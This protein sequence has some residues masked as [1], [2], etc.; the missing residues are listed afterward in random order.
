MGKHKQRSSSS[1]SS[2]R[3]K[4]K[5]KHHHQK[6]EVKQ[7]HVK[8]EEEPQPIQ[9]E[10]IKEKP[11]FEA[12]G[13]LAQYAENALGNGKVLKFTIPFDAKIPTANWQ[14]FP[15][16]GTQ[17]YPSI[18]LKGKSVFL[19]GK[20]KEI[21]DILVENL[22]VSKQHCVIQFREIKK[23]NGQ[24]E[25]LSYIKPYAMDLEST[26]GTY[27]NEQ[28]LEPARYYELLEEDVLRFGKS[29]REYVLIKS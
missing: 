17:S 10:I 11:C 29:D 18:S 16:K 22:S 23:V 28:Q 13:I 4:H 6:K 21:V 8:K 26:N 24:G 1:S 14:I 20:D 25:V 3:K 15:F 5:K 12:S 2:N 27:L 9:P 19:I 7:E